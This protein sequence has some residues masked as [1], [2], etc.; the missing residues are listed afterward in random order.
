M[1]SV[2]MFEH[3]I[4]VDAFINRPFFFPPC[5]LAVLPMIKL[6]NALLLIGCAYKDGYYRCVV[7][8]IFESFCV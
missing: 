8:Q 6:Q 4:F 3:R 2:V 5:I 7:C 1:H